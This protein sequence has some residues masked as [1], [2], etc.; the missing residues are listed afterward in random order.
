MEGKSG[1]IM[2]Q[3]DVA[4]LLSFCHLK[5]VENMGFVSMDSPEFTLWDAVITMDPGLGVASSHITLG[6][7]KVSHSADSNMTRT[8]ITK[9][10]G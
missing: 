7:D 4:K 1:R 8:Q 5:K 3:E 10:C 9:C 6:N 2:S